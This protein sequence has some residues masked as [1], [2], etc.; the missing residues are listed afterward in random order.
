MPLDTQNAILNYISKHQDARA[1]G[2]AA[3]RLGTAAENGRFS[4]EAE[5]LLRAYRQEDNDADI[6]K[7]HQA[8]PAQQQIEMTP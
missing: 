6:A 5:E 2:L 1:R 8:M 3:Q 7:L 4:P